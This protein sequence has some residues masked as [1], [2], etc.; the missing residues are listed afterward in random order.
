MSAF[1]HVLG[2]DETARF[3]ECGMSKGREVLAEATLTLRNTGV[4]FHTDT[5]AGSAAEVILRMAQALLLSSVRYH[6]RHHATI[7]VLVVH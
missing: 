3:L 6:V 4:E 1:S 2:D 5:V 7:P